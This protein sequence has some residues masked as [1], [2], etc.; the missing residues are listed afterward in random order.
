MKWTK[1]TVSFCSLPLQSRF[2]IFNVSPSCLNWF[3]ARLYRV[4][5]SKIC[6]IIIEELKLNQILNK[7]MRLI[8]KAN[9]MNLKN[10]AS[11]LKI[12]WRNRKRALLFPVIGQQGNILDSWTSQSLRCLY[13]LSRGIWMS[14]R[15]TGA[16]QRFDEWVARRVFGCSWHRRFLQKASRYL[17]KRPILYFLLSSKEI[18][19]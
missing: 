7:T 5:S 15:K 16:S 6:E 10:K 17:T 19:S 18:T 13:K 2:A 1:N 12:V 3:F 4:A 11:V 8:C 14:L 9:L